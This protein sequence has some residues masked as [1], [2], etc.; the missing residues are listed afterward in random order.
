MHV[1]FKFE[2]L[3]IFVSRYVWIVSHHCFHFIRD[4]IDKDFCNSSTLFL[5]LLFPSHVN[6][7]E[8]RVINQLRGDNHGNASFTASSALL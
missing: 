6:A 5:T 2:I 8:S 4:L 3:R 1:C 7:F